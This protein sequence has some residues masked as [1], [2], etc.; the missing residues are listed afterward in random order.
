MDPTKAG[1]SALVNDGYWKEVGGE[2]EA[3]IATYRKGLLT[4][5]AERDLLWRLGYLLLREGQYEE[6]WPLVDH[7]EIRMDTG[8]IDKPKLSFPEWRGEPVRSLLVFHEQGLGDQIMYARFIPALKARGI[9]VTLLCHPALARLFEHFGV[10]IIPATKGK[11]RLPKREAWTLIT[12]LAY[13]LSV[14]LQNLPAEPYLPG[15]TNGSGIGLVTRGSPTH[16]NDRMRSLPADLAT[17][18]L[19]W[20]GV[21]SLHPEDTGAR[22][23][24]DTAEI[25]RGLDRVITVDTSVAHLAAAMG[26]PTFILLPAVNSDWRWLRDRSDSPWYPSARLLRQP[27][28]GNWSALVTKI[29][30]E[31]VG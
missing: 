21:R 16:R 6:A 7:H 10:E 20:P 17:E 31:L 19:S 28:P 1:V 4:Y 22:D 12:S 8:S 27:S 14:T 18:M 2:Y 24:E 9:E 15:A 11:L 23:M 13:R 25:V 29:R 3:A 26:K 5:P 30:G